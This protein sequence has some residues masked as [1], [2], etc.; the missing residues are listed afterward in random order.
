MRKDNLKAGREKLIF[1]GDS[2]VCVIIIAILILGGELIFFIGT[3]LNNLISN[4]GKCS[5]QVV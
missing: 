2:T 4:T 1:Y 5:L 3:W